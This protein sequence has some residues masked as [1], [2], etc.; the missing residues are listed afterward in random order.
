MPRVV[1]LVPQF[2]E[3]ICTLGYAEQLVARSHACDYPAAVL[4]V[5]SCTEPKAA[6]PGI[7]YSLGDR[8]KALIQEGLSAYR[9]DAQLLRDLRP[10]L[11]ITRFDLPSAGIEAAD[12]EQAV[13]QW[14]GHDVRLINFD[15]AAISDIWVAFRTFAA[16]LGPA[17]VGVRLA[18]QLQQR[19]AAIV[20]QATDCSQRPRAA[21]LAGLDPLLPASGFIRELAEMAGAKVVPGG[22][23]TTPIPIDW[24]ALHQADPDTILV[25]LSNISKEHARDA[26]AVW[27][28]RDEWRSLRAVQE[29]AVAL[30]DG[31]AP[32]SHLGPRVVNAL[33]I[34]A[35]IIHPDEFQFGHR[36]Q[37]WEPL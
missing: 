8:L 4:A 37:S 36:G 14:F 28:E 21:C 32:F 34:V 3:I 20:R 5:P 12:L 17:E 31:G 1:S 19:M 26:I 16:E 29:G 15:L 7:G 25:M 9:V 22:R 13:Q 30:C 24:P 23:W 33:E 6:L 18:M 35:E 10:D 2:T 11:I 27:S